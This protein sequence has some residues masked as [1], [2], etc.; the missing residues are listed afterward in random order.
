MPRVQRSVL[1]VVGEAQE[2]ARLG[3]KR[4]VGAQLA[5]RGQ[6]EDRRARAAAA[7]AQ[8]GELAV[9]G[10]LAAPVCDAAPETDPNRRWNELRVQAGAVEPAVLG[11][12]DGLRQTR[13]VF[14]L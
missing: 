3:R 13:A 1:S 8:R 6:T 5:H 11:D 7:G 14:A 9:V 2:L 12:G 10:G 4:L